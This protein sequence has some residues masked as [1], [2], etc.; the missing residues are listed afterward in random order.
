M[1]CTEKTSTGEFSCDVVI[2][3]PVDANDS[4]DELD[5]TDGFDSKMALIIVVVAIVI[6]VLTLVIICCL[7]KRSAN[8]DKKTNQDFE[9]SPVAAQGAVDETDK[10]PEMSVTHGTPDV[11][12]KA[13]NESNLEAESIEQ[14]K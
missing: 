4:D 1:Y 9:N 6:F 8:K 3:A 10:K 7:K 5:T 2:N 12:F 11:N 14:L 13:N